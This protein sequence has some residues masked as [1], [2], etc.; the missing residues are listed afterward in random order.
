LVIINGDL[1]CAYLGS[2]VVAVPEELISAASVIRETCGKEMSGKE[3]L[4]PRS[5][6]DHCIS[7]DVLKS[8]WTG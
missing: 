3:I 5:N 6:D 7:E 4:C 2:N 1:I 8:W